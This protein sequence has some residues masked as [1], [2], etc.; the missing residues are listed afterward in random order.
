L[1]KPVEFLFWELA[2]CFLEF[3]NPVYRQLFFQICALA[4]SPSETDLD[5]LWEFS[6]EFA[7]SLTL[8]ALLFAWDLSGWL[9]RRF[10]TFTEPLSFTLTI[11]R[12]L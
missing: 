2:N 3:K 8:D 12:V 10:E 1:G 4:F 9:K 5:S 6:G 11:L 7:E